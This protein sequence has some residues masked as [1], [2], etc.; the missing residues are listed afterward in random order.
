NNINIKEW[1]TVNSDPHMCTV[2]LVGTD[3][4]GNFIYE[5]SAVDNMG[6]SYFMRSVYYSITLAELEQ[7]AK[8]ALD[9]GKITNE[10]YKNILKEAE[11]IS[12]KDQ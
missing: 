6:P 5:S 8:Q 12:Q 9:N 1:F 7:Y 2:S 4:D 10:Q 11:E 3:T